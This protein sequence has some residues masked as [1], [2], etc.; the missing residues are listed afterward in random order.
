MTANSYPYFINETTET[1]VLLFSVLL[2][3]LFLFLFLDTRETESSQHFL[4]WRA[5]QFL[6]TLRVS[7]A[8]VVF[9]NSWLQK[10]SSESEVPWGFPAFSVG[11]PPGLQL[12]CLQDVDKPESQK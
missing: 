5:A 7:F 11:D 4:G 2:E 8:D 12:T 9:K 1:P 10:C 6:G 3:L